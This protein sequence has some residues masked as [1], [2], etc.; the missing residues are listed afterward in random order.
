MRFYVDAFNL[1]TGKK[2]H[3][4]VRKQVCAIIIIPQSEQFGQPW[5]WRI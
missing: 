2:K 5:L 3:N 1:L 4:F